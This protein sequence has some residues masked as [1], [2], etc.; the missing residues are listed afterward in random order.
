MGISAIKNKLTALQ[1]TKAA[2][3]TAIN[4]MGVEAAEDVPFSAYAEK[5]L[6]IPSG[7]ELPEGVYTVTVENSEPDMGTVSGGGYVSSGMMVT[8]EAVPNS[9]YTFTGWARYKGN[10]RFPT[11]IEE[12][13]HTFT[14][15]GNLR[16]VAQFE[17][18]S[19]ST[20]GGGAMD[21]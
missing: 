18:S 7:S 16:F 8:I 9:G 2:I 4:N 5:I 13:A 10:G 12:Q 20:V 17:A 19:P 14:V 3:R 6:S 11:M 21:P 1:N 15:T